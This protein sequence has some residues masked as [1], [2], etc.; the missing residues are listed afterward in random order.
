MEKQPLPGFAVRGE[1]RTLRF[2]DEFQYEESRDERGNGEK[3]EDPSATESVR[4]HSR[5]QDTENHKK[6]DGLIILQPQNSIPQKQN[7]LPIHEEG[8]ARAKACQ[9]QPDLG[10]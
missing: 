5:E 9:Q 8:R 6:P 4:N 7:S 3:D 2:F 10:F 1:C